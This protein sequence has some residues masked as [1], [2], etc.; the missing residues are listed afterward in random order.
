MGVIGKIILS[1]SI[2][3]YGMYFLNSLLIKFYKL[4]DIHSLKM[5]PVLFIGIVFLSWI[6]VF[7]LDKIPFLKKFAGT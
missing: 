6:I 3:S 1:I 2:C 4:L 7:L 5:L